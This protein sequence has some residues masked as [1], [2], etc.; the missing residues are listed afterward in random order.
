MAIVPNVNDPH[1][2]EMLKRMKDTAKGPEGKDR[3]KQEYNIDLNDN[4]P[5]LGE[6]PKPVNVKTK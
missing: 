4:Q 6:K 5:L 2:A 1:R 3:L